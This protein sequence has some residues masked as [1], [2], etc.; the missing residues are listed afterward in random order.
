MFACYVIKPVKVENLLEVQ[1][2]HGVQEIPNKEE[3]HMKNTCWMSIK[4]PQ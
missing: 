4:C 1:G 3:K 2:G